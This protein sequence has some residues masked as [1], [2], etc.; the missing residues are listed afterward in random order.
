MPETDEGT[1]TWAGALRSYRVDGVNSQV[2][3]SLFPP[4]TLGQVTT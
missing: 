2:Q 4:R 3:G 1:V